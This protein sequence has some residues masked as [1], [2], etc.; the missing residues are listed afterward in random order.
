[1]DPVINPSTP[2][3]TPGDDLKA[4]AHQCKRLERLLVWSL[5][6]MLLVVFSINIYFSREAKAAQYRCN[7]VE[8]QLDGLKQIQPLIRD[9]V[10]ALQQYAAQDKDFMPIWERYRPALTDY[11][12]AQKSPAPAPAPRK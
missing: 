9:F 6:A 8:A 3:N 11:L 12:P 2:G 10:G 1:M 7:Q 4:V 5:A